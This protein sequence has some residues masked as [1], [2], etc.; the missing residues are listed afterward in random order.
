MNIDSDYL[1]KKLKAIQDLQKQTDYL[2][3]KLLIKKNEKEWREQQRL[4][5]KANKE[6][7]ELEA[8]EKKAAEKRAKDIFQARKIQ[9]LEDERIINSMKPEKLAKRSEKPF[10]TR[11]LNFEEL[12]P[13][14]VNHKTVIYVKPGSDIEALKLKY[15]YL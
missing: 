2:P 4:E 11:K 6:K 1:L 13:V 12:I 7:A 14:R 5:K 8:K 9:R 3:E 10:P 15:K